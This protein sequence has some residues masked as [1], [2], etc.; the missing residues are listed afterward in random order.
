MTNS[1]ANNGNPF[2]ASD[3][4]R[5]KGR[6]VDTGLMLVV[7]SEALNRQLRENMREYEAA[8][9]RALDKENYEIPEGVT[10]QEISAGNRGRIRI[11]HLFR[12]FR[13]LV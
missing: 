5:N 4:L 1:A 9:V 3:Y 6:L 7:D 2:G 8:S 11:L 10:R 13:F 12:W